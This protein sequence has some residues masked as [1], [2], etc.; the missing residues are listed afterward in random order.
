MKIDPSGSDR[1]NCFIYIALHWTVS[2]RTQATSVLLELRSEEVGIN[3]L[4]RIRFPNWLRT[5][6]N[7]SMLGGR[8]CPPST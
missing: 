5:C 6:V 1:L 4:G 7:T 3:R 8:T 2:V